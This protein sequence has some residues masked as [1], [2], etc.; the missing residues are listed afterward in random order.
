ML[1]RKMIEMPLEIYHRIIWFTICSVHSSLYNIYALSLTC[2]SF[3]NFI[4]GYELHNKNGGNKILDRIIPEIRTF[5]STIIIPKSKIQPIVDTLL[6]DNI[7]IKGFKDNWNNHF[8]V[9]RENILSTKKR[10]KVIINYTINSTYEQYD[11][12]KL[13]NLYMLNFPFPKILESKSLALSLV[14][15]R[16]TMNIVIT[17]EKLFYLNQNYT[18]P[19]EALKTLV[20]IASVCFL[21]FM[22][23]GQISDL[24]KQ[25]FPLIFKLKMYMN[26]EEN[27]LLV[28]ENQI[29]F[30]FL[31]S[32]LQSVIKD[33]ALS[34]IFIWCGINSIDE[35]NHLPYYNVIIKWK[36]KLLPENQHQLI[37]MCDE[38]FL[39]SNRLTNDYIKINEIM[40][41]KRTG[42]KLYISMIK[43]E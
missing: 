3:L 10:I 43:F 11:F 33:F 23:I 6:I 32:S 17:K 35:K 26:E 14:I 38:I 2:K 41:K 16:V 4:L 25:I 29:L 20:D 27:R 39:R 13:E 21:K 5:A 15:S 42:V 7:F 36:K 19:E 18:V 37:L 30:N 8:Y 12:D 1:Q 9:Q 31:Q 40:C 28:K 24:C 34:S 22:I